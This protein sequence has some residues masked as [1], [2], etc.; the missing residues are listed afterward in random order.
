MRMRPEFYAK[1]RGSR[2]TV[3]F[4]LVCIL[5]AFGLVMLASTSA[6]NGYVKFRDAGYY[7]KK[8]LFA[9]S[10]GLAA[11]VAVS[12]LDYRLLRFLAVPA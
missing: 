1:H 11:M 2:D 9:T 7:V 3:L 6:W 12:R 8:Q 5:T 10:L 4:V